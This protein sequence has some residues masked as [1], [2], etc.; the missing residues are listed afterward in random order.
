[1]RGTCVGF[2][3]RQLHAGRLEADAQLST[4]EVLD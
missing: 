3:F 4:H 2:V 1:M